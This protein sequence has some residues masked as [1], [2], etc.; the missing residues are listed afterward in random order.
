MSLK[1]AQNLDWVLLMYSRA[2]YVFRYMIHELFSTQYVIE[3]QDFILHK[4]IIEYIRLKLMPNLQVQPE[5]KFHVIGLLHIQGS[6]KITEWQCKV[7]IS[8]TSPTKPIHV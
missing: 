8:K 3:V 5:D 4:S 7:Q 1:C 6:S 2:I